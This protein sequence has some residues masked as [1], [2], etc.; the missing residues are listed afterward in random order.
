[1][2]G[3]T[4]WTFLALTCGLVAHALKQ[5]IASRRLGAPVSTRQYWIEHWPETTLAVIC[6]VV[7]YLGLPEIAAAWPDMATA[8]GLTGQQTILSSFV[9]G[10]VSNSL[11]DFLGGRVRTLTGAP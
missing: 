7:L 11:A 1:M 6:A 10:F 8:L 5:Y 3:I 4:L 2:T 9:A